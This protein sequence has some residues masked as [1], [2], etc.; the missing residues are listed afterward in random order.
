LRWPWQN[1]KLLTRA[2]AL[3]NSESSFIVMKRMANV[4]KMVE[5]QPLVDWTMKKVRRPQ[6]PPS[7]LTRD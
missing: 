4:P 3:T 7:L 5:S 1:L 2:D 6:H